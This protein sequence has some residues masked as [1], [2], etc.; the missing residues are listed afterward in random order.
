MN[1]VY[2][3]IGFEL[4]DIFNQSHGTIKSI[5]S[6]VKIPNPENPLSQTELS[7]PNLT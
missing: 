7:Q 6:K 2:G 4:N 3:K 1:Q 5:F